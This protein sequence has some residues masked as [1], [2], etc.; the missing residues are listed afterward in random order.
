ME[1]TDDS[2]CTS[3]GIFSDQNCS[4]TTTLMIETA[5]MQPSSLLDK[6][7]KEAK[8]RTSDLKVKV[9]NEK[10]TSLASM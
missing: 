1:N 10:I 5:V 7:A 9:K 8:H 6:I 3:T 2:N 4:K